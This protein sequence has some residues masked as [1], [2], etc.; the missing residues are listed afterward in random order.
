MATSGDLSLAIDTVI[1]GWEYGVE[2][3]MTHLGISDTMTFTATPAKHDHQDFDVPFGDSDGS[4]KVFAHF[5]IG[6]K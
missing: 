1:G 4:F 2:V 6:F 3:V 5:V